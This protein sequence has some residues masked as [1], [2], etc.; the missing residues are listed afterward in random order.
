V[1]SCLDGHD[2]T[3]G[4]IA[5]LEHMTARSEAELVHALQVGGMSAVLD[6]L[7][8]E[9]AGAR[10]DLF[11]ATLHFGTVRVAVGGCM[12]QQSAVPLVGRPAPCLLAVHYV[13][14]N[15]E[16]GGMR[17]RMDGITYDS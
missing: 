5:H 4:L 12:L 6:T 17:Q 11:V 10:L 14:C 9:L 2:V 15:A 7:N 1:A 16:N 13:N 8:S 3:G